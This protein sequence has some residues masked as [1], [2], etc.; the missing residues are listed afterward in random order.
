[1]KH[2]IEKCENLG[3][4][5]VINEELLTAC[6]T[7]LNSKAKFPKPEFHYR[8][9]SKERI[10]EYV[11]EFINRKLEIK[12]FKEKKKEAIRKAKEEMNHSFKIGQILYDSWGYEQT[13]I[14]FY[15]VTAV[16]P[17]S[18]EVKR[19][20][21][22]YAKNQPSGYSSMSAFVVPV[23]DAFVKPAERKPI[24]VLVNQNGEVSQYYIKSKH[25]WI[26]EYNAGEKGVYE[27]WY[28]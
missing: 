25:G 14:D 7:K 1:M 20:A 13:N 8:F 16:L 12:Q 23:P 26:S 17:K 9:R 24:Q 19:I 3:F 28:A 27:S 22:K 10:E 5:L 6:C 15:Q 18:I 2:L 4:A 11:N 21:S